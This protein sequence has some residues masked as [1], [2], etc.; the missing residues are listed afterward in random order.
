MGVFLFLMTL[1]LSV[2]FLVLA[3]TEGT[4][5]GGTLRLTVLDE[6]LVEQF[7][8]QLRFPGIFGSVLGQV[9][10]LGGVLAVV[11]AA[12]TLGSEYSWGTLRVQ[13][14]R[15]PRRGGYLFAK[16][17]TL[18]LV[19][20]IG[21]AIALAFGALLALAYGSILGNTGTMSVMDILL[22]PLGMLRALCVIL[23]YVLFTIAAATIGRSVIGGVAGGLIFLSL[24]GGLGTFSLFAEWG[25]PVFLFLY[26]LLLQRNISTLTVMNGQMYG[27]DTARFSGIDIATLPPQWQALLMIA[28]YSGLFYAYA[29][30]ALTRR[31]IGGAA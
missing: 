31:D 8:R 20:L 14:A 2:I 18:M 30:Y 9:N 21:I 6:A 29:H 5:T 17:L 10:G 16:V 27:I 19:V 24:D 23:P 13:L 12:G 4:F 3:L 11:L 7:R 25:N 28:I 1:S 22:L 15:Q 26:N